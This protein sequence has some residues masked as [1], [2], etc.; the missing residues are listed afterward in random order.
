MA[1]YSKFVLCVVAFFLYVQAG[2]CDGRS[3]SLNG[4][5]QI[6]FDSA[7]PWQKEKLILEPNDLDQIPRYPPTIGWD[8]MLEKGEAIST[9]ST[10]Q[11]TWETIGSA[12]ARN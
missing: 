12:T 2:F 10:S 3:V 9:P 11:I 5:W 6:W 1:R 4:Q 8:A 7:A